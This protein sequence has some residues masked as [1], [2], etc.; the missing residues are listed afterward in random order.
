MKEYS[1]E[2]IHYKLD[3]HPVTTRDKKYITLIV[4]TIQ[5]IPDTDA[6][7]TAMSCHYRFISAY[8][9]AE[10]YYIH[11]NPPCNKDGFIILDLIFFNFSEMEKDGLTDDR[12][13]DTIAHEIAHV[14][15]GHHRANNDK[16]TSEKEIEADDKIVEWGFN[17]GYTDEQIKQLEKQE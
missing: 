5:K 15:L 9:T 6:K 12:I 3:L 2:T 16:K 8:G 7:D 4:E 1:F 10:E 17:R 14:Y 13:K 11:K